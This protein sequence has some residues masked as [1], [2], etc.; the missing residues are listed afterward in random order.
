MDKI[1]SSQLAPFSISNSKYYL[2]LFLF[3]P[4]LAFL[5][6]ISDYSKKES[7]MVVYLFLI[8]Y[9]LTFVLGNAGN[10]AERYAL[11]MKNNADL[12]FSDFFKIIGGIYTSDTSVDIVEPLIS[13]F[14]SR[15][16]TYHGVLFAS[17]AALF[18]YFY[19]NSVNNLYDLYKNNN[20]WNTLFYLVFFILILPITAINGF[21]MW[22]A[23]WIFFFGAYHVILY[24][25]PRYLL[26]A[27]S[28]SLVHFSFLSANII[29]IIYFL[30]GNRNYIYLPIAMASFV[31]PHL[32]A[33]FFRSISLKLGGGL[34]SR[35]ET[36]S[37]KDY[38]IA[39]Q[40]AS[41]QSA[42]FLT[43]GNVVFFYYL[44]FAIVL[45][46]VRY[47]YLIKGKA[48]SNFYSF[49]L[50]FLAFVNFGKGIP[51][52]GERFQILFFLFA[53][54]Y[55]FLCFLK[56]PPNN[57]NLLTWIG[58]F[59]LL[60]RTAVTFRQGSESINAWILTP[61]LGLPL[62]VPNLSI[63]DFLFQ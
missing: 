47:G 18:G 63:F 10:D 15:F 3:W 23:A 56:L 34:H 42:W 8:Y 35:Y 62:L 37:N 11:Y 54:T 61:G 52:F 1:I 28:S 41:E 48:E 53:T 40:Q 24:R 17:Y 16:T 58:I 2:I 38:I 51:S 5:T 36:Y 30:A 59:P 9:G 49:L 6:A 20:G 45:M 21:R 12:P 32:L 43:L 4:F 13:F 27:L 60:L 44:L 25:N 22:T 57:I 19:L 46:H 55:I 14:I 33:P 26:I 7:K 29:L 50:L 31:L 39:T